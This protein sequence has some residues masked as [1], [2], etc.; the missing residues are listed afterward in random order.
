MTRTQGYTTAAVEKVPNGYGVIEAA[1]SS[2]VEVE[3]LGGATPI[4]ILGDSHVLGFR[5]LFCRD[6]ASGGNY[7]TVARYFPG[8]RG[9]SFYSAG[10]FSP[11]F[12]AALEHD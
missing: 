11:A 5:H 10:G 2:G 9:E 3:P 7:Y 6:S 1:P 8:L 12:A 4:Y